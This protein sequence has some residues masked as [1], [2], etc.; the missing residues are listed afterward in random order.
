MGKMPF[1]GIAQI[2]T[3][4][5]PLPATPEVMP[6]RPPEQGPS[7]LRPIGASAADVRPVSRRATLARWWSALKRMVL[8]SPR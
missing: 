2:A 4:K 7:S 6:V 3:A 8:E 1:R 5:P